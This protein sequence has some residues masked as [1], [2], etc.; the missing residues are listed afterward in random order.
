MGMSHLVGRCCGGA[1]GGA[2]GERLGRGWLP[3]TVPPHVN[4]SAG[5]EMP[6]PTFLLRPANKD[7]QV[8]TVLDIH[9]GQSD[10][11]MIGGKVAKSDRP[12]IEQPMQRRPQPRQN[13][14]VQQG[15]TGL[16]APTTRLWA[17]RF[18]DDHDCTVP[19]DPWS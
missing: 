7:D 13:D 12:R 16:A 10:L 17:G 9:H 2:C 3:G 1:L 4:R 19:V 6:P 11:T 8:Q 18:V 15:L 5:E 14:P